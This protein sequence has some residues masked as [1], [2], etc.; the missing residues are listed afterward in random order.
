[1]PSEY[2]SWMIDDWPGILPHHKF[3]PLYT[4]ATKRPKEMGD[5]GGGWFNLSSTGLLAPGASPGPSIVLDETPSLVAFG[6]R[7]A[8]EAELGG[9]LSLSA[10]SHPRSKPSLP[11]QGLAQ[12]FWLE[13][14]R[15]VSLPPCLPAF[16]PFP[17]AVPLTQPFT[18]TAARIAFP[19]PGFDHVTSLPW[20]TRVSPSGLVCQI[21]ISNH[22]H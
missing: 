8:L 19:F 14:A 21:S 9:T 15:A 17:S 3:V 18:S 22:E 4:Q 12:V 13:L 2:S 20:K 10:H 1:V 5:W 11:R 7:W 16:S 6:E